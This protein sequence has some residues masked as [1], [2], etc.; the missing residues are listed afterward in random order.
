MILIQN[1]ERNVSIQVKPNELLL[2]TYKDSTRNKT[3]NSIAKGGGKI[4]DSYYS[5]YSFP[6][7]P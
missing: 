4:I 5:R 7:Q 1:I 2:V 6:D 3:R